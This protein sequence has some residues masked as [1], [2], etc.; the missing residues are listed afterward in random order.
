MINNVTQQLLRH[1]TR[2]TTYLDLAAPKPDPS[3]ERSIPLTED[4]VQRLKNVNNG[5]PAFSPGDRRAQMFQQAVDSPH[6]YPEKIEKQYDKNGVP[7]QA[8]GPSSI[9]LDA[10]KHCNSLPRGSDVLL[11]GPHCSTVADEKILGCKITVIEPDSRA[12]DALLYK[13]EEAGFSFDQYTQEYTKN[14]DRGPTTVKIF[15]TDAETF[16]RDPSQ[17]VKYDFIADLNASWVHSKNGPEALMLMQK[18][19]KPSGDILGNV[20]GPSE[21]PKHGN[22]ANLEHLPPGAEIKRVL[23]ISDPSLGFTNVRFGENPNPKV[24]DSLKKELQLSPRLGETALERITALI[25]GNSS[26]S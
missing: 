16:L 18:A 21:E 1:A 26:N 9:D 12:Q 10:V 17:S 14:S 5:T 2:A 19:I 20:V 25:K 3:G 15:N 6:G 23:T 13:L 22:A 11:V 7:M 24:H 8:T 4:L